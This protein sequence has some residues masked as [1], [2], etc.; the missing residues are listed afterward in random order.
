MNHGVSLVRL[1]NT[2]FNIQSKLPSSNSKDASIIDYFRISMSP[3]DFE[4]RLDGNRHGCTG[5]PRSS[6][7]LF[8]ITEPVSVKCCR[9]SDQTFTLLNYRSHQPLL[10][11]PFMNSLKPCGP[12]QLE[13]LIMQ[14]LLLVVV[15]KMKLSYLI[16]CEEFVPI[17]MPF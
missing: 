1:N 8:D 9:L 12:L 15:L 11:S 10:Q 16:T 6:G 7:K 13:L 14:F 2:E 17:Q 5:I 4:S 3:F